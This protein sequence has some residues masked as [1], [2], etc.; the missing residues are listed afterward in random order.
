MNH[1]WNTKV[2]ELFEKAVSG[3]QI[4][5]NKQIN[6]S[7]V[8]FIVYAVSALIQARSV[9]FHEIA[10]KMD[11]D[12]KEESNLRRIQHFMSSYNLDMEFVMMLILLLLPCNCKIR[13][14]I[15]RTNWDF[16]GKSHN[17]LVV[18][19]YTHGVGIPLWFECLDNKGGNSD[20]DDRIYVILCL[21]KQLDKKR[22]KCVIGDCEFIGKEWIDF[23][24]GEK[25]PFY[26]DVRTNQYFEHEGTRYQIS[27]YMSVRS[28]EKY[29]SKV[30]IFGHQLNL[31]MK[32]MKTDAQSGRKPLLAIVTSEKVN[33]A[34]S[35]YK[36]RWSIEVLFQSLKGR[37]FNLEETHIKDSIRL[38]KLFALCAIAFTIVFLVGL[39][40][41][42]KTPITV[43]KHGYKTNSFFRHGLNFARKALK[44]NKKEKILLELEENIC[45]VFEWLSNLLNDNLRCFQK[46]VM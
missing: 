43:K 18:T 3:V 21:L 5:E 16:G 23:L 19:A 37:G 4:I 17:V 26:F 7:R 27:K 46:I 39:S 8:D 14:S 33:K 44:K 38:R 24:V 32:Q 42:E 36:T 30:T 9:S 35:N 25:I 22:I 28:K 1:E 40:L 31:A 45:Y 6:K 41:A 11:T 15:D 34:L 10:D 2:A 20:S 13:L 12:C 29:L